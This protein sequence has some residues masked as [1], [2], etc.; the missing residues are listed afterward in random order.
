MPVE[1]V[2]NFNAGPAVLP[3]P[4]LETA[5]RDLP[6]LPGVGMSV[7][8]VSHRSAAV[9]EILERAV[10]DVRRAA[11]VP[12][13]FHV[14]FLPG[15]ATQQF[16]MAPLNLLPA[17][18]SADYVLTGIWSR[19]AYEEAARC[20]AARV[21]GSTEREQFRRT[22]DA[23][24][25]DLADSAAYLHV[26]SNNTICGTQWRAL[27]EGGRAPLVVD[28]SSDV[29]S[30]P[31]PIGRLG[32]VYACAQK[33]LGPA[34]VTLVI[35]R[36]DLVRRTP[37]RADLPAMLRYATHAAAASRYNT[38]PVFAI[39]LVGLVVRW[40]LANGGLAGMARRNERKA[41][42][43]YQ[44]IDRTPFYRGTAGPASRSL[45]NVT[46]RLPAAEL[47][48]R[49]VDEAEAAGLVGLRGHRAVGGVRASIYNACPEAA[50]DAL[51]AFM[52][53]FERTRG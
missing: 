8:E 51:V 38:P 26:T 19:K 30:R 44:A 39:Y 41:R 46:F 36:D 27:P 2:F 53:E 45:M 5:Q 20:G 3:E 13:H 21:A 18:G 9:D 40:V 10:A 28:A 12:D 48:T 34:G 33:N 37:A 11:G 35:V 17:G 6:A 43:L 1:R 49:F 24:E 25:L 52:A 22:P 7:L 14:L 4:V 16:A 47:E 15:G 42:K 23:G 31:I 50:V 32:L 29:F